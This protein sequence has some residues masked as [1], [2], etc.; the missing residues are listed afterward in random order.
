MSKKTERYP[1]KPPVDVARARR[2]LATLAAELNWA[3]VMRRSRD[4]ERLDDDF[5]QKLMT[6]YARAPM[7]SN[8]QEKCEMLLDVMKL[9]QARGWTILPEYAALRPEYDR[10]FELVSFEFD[11]PAQQR[12]WDLG[13]E[14]S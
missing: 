11:D 1:K 4:A 2:P 14:D 12:A 6:E 9:F 3:R 7:P 5:Y 10:I 13:L 8:A